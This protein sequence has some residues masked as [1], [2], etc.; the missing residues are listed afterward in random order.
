MVTSFD[1]VIDLGLVLVDDYKLNKLY[2]N[3]PEDFYKFL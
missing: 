3:S 1:E 2:M